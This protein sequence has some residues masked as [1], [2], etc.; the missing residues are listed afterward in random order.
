MNDGDVSPRRRGKLFVGVVG[1]GDLFGRNGFEF[2]SDGV[3][4]ETGGE[5]A[6]VEASDFVVGDFASRDFEFA[7]DAMANREAL[8]FVVGGGFDGGLDI[9]IRNAASAE[10]ARD[11]EFSLP[12]NLRALPRKLLRV[13]RVVELPVFFHAGHD[14]LGEQLV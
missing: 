11:P 12:A 3:G 14:D 10:V 7:L 2:F 5:E 13:A 8:R 4:R 6:A 1:F 9:G